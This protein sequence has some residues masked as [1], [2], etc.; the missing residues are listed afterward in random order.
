MKI[1]RAALSWPIFLLLL[2]A[3]LLFNYVGA[4]FSNFWLFFPKAPYFIALAF[5]LLAVWQAVAIVRSAKTHIRILHW[6]LLV[7]A[8]GASALAA[9]I[10]FANITVSSN[11]AHQLPAEVAIKDGVI[12]IDG[13]IDSSLPNKI[14]Q[15]LRT[16]TIR[17]VVIQSLGGQISP[18]RE[19]ADKLNERAIPIRMGRRCASACVHLWA[20]TAKRQVYL[21]SIIGIHRSHLGDGKPARGFVAGLLEKKDKDMAAL[22]TSIGFPQAL[23]TKAFTQPTN[24]GTWLS[25]ADLEHYGVA[26]EFI[27]FDDE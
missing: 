17:L 1:S 2:A 20:L 16:N 15:L 14:D 18:A 13:S 19:I 5:I 26:T 10:T 27:R 23:I 22:L 7:P 9:L 3:A 11:A 12:H 21:S 24:K 6:L 25:G 8:L 4:R